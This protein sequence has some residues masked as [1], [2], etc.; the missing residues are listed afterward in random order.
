MKRPIDLTAFGLMIL[1]CLT[2]GLQQTAMKLAAPGIDPMLQ[3]GLRSA[4]AAAL[5]F[6]ISR[7]VRRDRWLPRIFLGP[8]LLAGTLFALE[9]LLVA[10]GLRWT[11]ASHIGVFLYT[12]PI[13]AAI[14]LHFA[15]P[16]ERMARVQWLGVAITF[17]GVA[18]I[19]LLPELRGKQPLAPSMIVGDLL[20]LGAGIAW[21]LTTVVIRTSRLANAPPSQTLTNQLFVAGIVALAFSAMTGR[22]DMQPSAGDLVNLGFQ[23]IIICTVSFMIWFRLLQIYPSS[24]LGVLSLMTPVFGVISGA[25]LLGEHLTPD[26]LFGGALVLLGMLTVQA[27]DLLLRRRGLR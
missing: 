12:G 14:G 19:F 26:F 16:D 11:T 7:L 18:A 20:G 2:W 10:E 17:T 9:F 22:L 23:T 13:F 8:G 6:A 5:V 21:G 1:L 27:H 3:I 15:Q 24:R 25:L 4:M